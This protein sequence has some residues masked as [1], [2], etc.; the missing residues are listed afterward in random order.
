MSGTT[1]ILEGQP[2]AVVSGAECA[3]RCSRIEGLRPIGRT[4]RWAC[5]M[6]CDGHFSSRRKEEPGTRKDLKLGTCR[7][8]LKD[9]SSAKWQDGEGRS[10]SEGGE[11]G[12]SKG[13]PLRGNSG[14]MA[15][16]LVQWPSDV[17]VC[18]SLG[19]ERLRE[20]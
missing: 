19:C 4:H 16:G 7:I 2:R 11:Q 3:R 10:G 9:H 1:S 5:S 12:A 8:C 18:G 17:T 13:T 20:G 14:E 6:F 15:A